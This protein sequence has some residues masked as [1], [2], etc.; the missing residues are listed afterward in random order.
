MNFITDKVM[1]PLLF[2]ALSLTF[3]I[4]FL[5]YFNLPLNLA[6]FSSS[7]LSL[8]LVEQS[9]PFRLVGFLWIYIFRTFPRRRAKRAL[10]IQDTQEKY[11]R[12]CKIK[13]PPKYNFNLAHMAFCAV[14]YKQFPSG[15]PCPNLCK[16]KQD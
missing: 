14:G 8:Y 9:S 5:E 7:I 12:I 15:N 10:C 13:H 11:V 4:I 6:L 1:Y 2:I 3:F 16:D